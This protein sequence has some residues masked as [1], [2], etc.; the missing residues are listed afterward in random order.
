MK[1]FNLLYL[2]VVL[3]FLIT[4]IGRAQVARPDYNSGTGFFVLD[5]KLYDATGNEF[6][7]IGANTAVYWQNE[8]NGMKSFPDMKK[9]GANCA[10]IVSVTNSSENLWSWQSNYLKQRACVKA[11]VD[12]KIIPILEFHDVTCGDTYDTPGAAKNLKKCVDYWC[13]SNLVKLCKDY[14]KYLIVNVANEWGPTNTGW[15]DGY[16]KAITAMRAAGIKNTILIDAGGCGQ[17]P[18]T[19]VNYGQ[20]LINFDPEH[21]IL[22]AIHFYGMWMTKEKIK[23]SWQYYVEDFLQMF[24]TKKLPVIVGEFGWTGAPENFTLYDPQKIISE[25]NRQGIG[26]LFWAWNSQTN[27]TY[28]NIVANY[29]KGYSTDADLTLH[30][31]H[32][33]QQFKE[34]AKEAA[35]FLPTSAFVHEKKMGDQISFYPN[36]LNSSVLN[37]KYLDVDWNDYKL[38]QVCNMLGQTVK[39]YKVKDQMPEQLIMDGIAPGTYYLH[40]TGEGKS[41]TSK[42]VIAN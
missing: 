9:A 5:G 41:F 18:S 21:N 12:N 25:C 29:T 23:A 28:Y 27:E 14:E 42:L 36:P 35:A 2:V 16:K 26:W 31:Q 11:C 3:L 30:G 19:I 39:S 15:R 22:F 1:R 8:A 4:G 34:N 17:N 24:K 7:P 33:V 40:F 10:R 32:I 13:T 37:I 38:I 20:E 6:T